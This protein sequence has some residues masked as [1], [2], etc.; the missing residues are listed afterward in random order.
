MI[1]ISSNRTTEWENCKA[2]Y[3]LLSK[4]PHC[5]DG[6]MEVAQG[7]VS[8][9]WGRTCSRYTA[10]QAL[11]NGASGQRNL[12]FDF[13]VPVATALYFQ[14]TPPSMSHLNG[15]PYLVTQD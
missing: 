5:T 12:S 6:E 15:G 10:L 3:H 4:C 8:V 9:W 7:L 2:A 13:S 1:Y 11:D 14:L